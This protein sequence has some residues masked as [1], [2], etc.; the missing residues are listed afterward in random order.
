MSAGD[1][2]AITE[3]VRHAEFVGVGE[4]AALLAGKNWDRTP[5]GARASWPQSLRTAVSICL[6]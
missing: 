6:S 2:K 4:M 3:V 5:I 1:S